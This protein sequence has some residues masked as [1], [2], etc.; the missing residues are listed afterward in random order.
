MYGHTCPMSILIP[1]CLSLNAG[2]NSDNMAKWMV[3]PFATPLS[4]VMAN[5]FAVDGGAIVGTSLI[6]TSFQ[7]V[8][9]PHTRT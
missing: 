4:S 2:G 5:K 6:L 3:R 1:F 9:D 8:C 7:D